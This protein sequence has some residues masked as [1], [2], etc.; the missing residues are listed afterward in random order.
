MP[1]ALV[2]HHPQIKV[3]QAALKGWLE[4]CL[5]QLQMQ[6]AEVSVLLTDDAEIQQLNRD[7]R[8][9]DKPTDILS[10]GM[11]EHR[12]AADPLP[13]HP[14]VLGD[15][16]VSLTTLRRQAEEREVDLEEELRYILAHG[17][18][19]LLG[20][21]HARPVEAKRMFALQDRLVS[22]NRRKR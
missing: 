20:Y 2:N 8:G 15:L 12:R 10:F 5:N 19:H 14:E 13:P 9:V 22:L 17:L 18:L 7:Y 3:R 4:A 16:V 11:R 21:D 6:G 1:L